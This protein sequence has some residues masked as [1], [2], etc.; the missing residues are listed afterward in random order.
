M[1]M[2]FVMGASTACGKYD[3]GLNMNTNCMRY[4]S[5]KHAETLYRRRCVQPVINYFS[6]PV[7]SFGVPL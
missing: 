4:S 1:Q 5:I 3:W 6:S 7:G 2:D